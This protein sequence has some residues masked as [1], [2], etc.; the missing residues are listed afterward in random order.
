MNATF[1]AWSPRMLAVLRIVTAL[2]YMEHGLMKFFAFPAPMPGGGGS[3]PVLLLVAACLE[4]IGPP[5]YPSRR[6]PA[7]RGDGHCLFHGSCPSQF[8][9]GPEW[10]RAANSLLLRFPILGVCRSRR[11][12]P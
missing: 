9:A 11:L 10:R 12:Q 2:L 5:L 6:L 4:T 7:L 1:E 8:L 3:L